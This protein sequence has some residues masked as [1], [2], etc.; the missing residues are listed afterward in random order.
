[1]PNARIPVIGLE[2]GQLLLTFTIETF[3]AGCT[4]GA[5][6][7]GRSG[8]I[9][10]QL[11]MTKAKRCAMLGRFPRLEEAAPSRTFS[12]SP[13]GDTALSAYQFQYSG[14]VAAEPGFRIERA[15]FAPAF[16]AGR[17]F[18]AIEAYLGGSGRTPTAFCAC[19]LRSPA[20]FTE[21]GFVAF[22]RHYVERLAPGG[23]S[24]T[25]STRWRARMSA[26]KSTRRRRRPSTPSATRC[27][28]MHGGG[29]VAAGS[30]E[31]R[32]AAPATPS[33]SSGAATSR[34]R[35][36]ATRRA[37]SSTSWRS[38]WRRS[39]S[40][41]RDVT[42][43]QVYTVFDVHSLLPTSSSAVARPGRPDLAFRAPAGPGP[44]F[45]GRRARRRP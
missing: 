27:R 40:A 28:L 22:N 15:R 44:R 26:R 30:G 34:P 29:F 11:R 24:A 41:G 18:D 2:S 10:G 16:A 38:A 12:P 19:E 45:R 32:E 39:A 9:L 6:Q 31:A 3:V 35:R 20:Q 17:R 37:S 33:A 8:E 43:T 5:V 21:A 13:P 7:S 4:Y 1:M 23:S 14:G 25:R 42:A 36:C